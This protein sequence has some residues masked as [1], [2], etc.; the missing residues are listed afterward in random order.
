MKPL[1]RHA[2]ETVSILMADDD[3]DDRMLT[4]E[5]LEETNFI[6]GFAEVS[7]GEDLL[8]YL[9]RDGKYA[10]LA[11]TPL[12]G[13]VLLDLNMPKMDGREALKEIKSDPALRR[14]P[15]I[16]LTTSR[17]DEDI[18][19]TYDLGANSFIAKPVTFD[20]LVGVMQ[21]VLH[22]WHEIVELPN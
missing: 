5:A 15:V 8:S 7:D 6:N 21:A 20:A 2:R 4:R 14:I 10:E 17:A 13:L 22:Y 11:G 3:P 12:P 9:R 16:V 1:E 18:L 19:Q